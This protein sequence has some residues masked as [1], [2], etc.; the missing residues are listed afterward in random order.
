VKSIA[1][2]VAGLVS[3]LLADAASANDVLTLS[4]ADQTRLGVST[5]QLAVSEERD[6]LY[7]IVRAVDPGS[8]FSIASD[9]ESAAAASSASGDELARL[10]KLARADNS[11]SRKSVQAARQQASS[12]AARLTLLKR[13]LA[14]EWSPAFCAMGADDLSSLA[15]AIAKG[16][17]AL[18]RADCPQ[19]PQGVLGDIEFALAPDTAPVTATPLGHSGSADAR[20]QTI[21]LYGVVKG[22]GAAQ[23]RPGRL[24]SG[25]IKTSTIISGVLV[26]RTAILRLNGDSF[27]YVKTGAETFERRQI[28]N[29]VMT[30]DGW[31]VTEGLS[32]GETIVTSG[33]GSMLAVERGDES[34]ESD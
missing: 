10:E 11:A 18:V 3:V 2:L 14:V 13:N 8:L 4:R 26:P 25:E 23:I 19:Q 12:D 21:G 32:S 28:S 7:A 16:E 9:L 1:I 6:G 30:A 20:L 24:F 34:A 29:A 17:A 27:V 22:D 5:G 15:D 31:F 33:V